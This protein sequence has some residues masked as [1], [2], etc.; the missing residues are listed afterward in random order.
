MWA[1]GTLIV[2]LRNLIK[3]E[4]IP[5]RSLLFFCSMVFKISP[6]NRLFKQVR[7]R[8][9]SRGFWSSGYGRRLMFQRSWVWIPAP[10]TGCKFGKIFTLI[11]CKN[12]IGC[13][14]RPKRGRGLAHFFFKKNQVKLSFIS[15]ESKIGQKT[16]QFQHGEENW[17]EW[18]FMILLLSLKTI[19]WD[20]SDSFLEGSAVKKRFQ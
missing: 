6:C 10:Y 18:E 16:I 17:S 11:C 13:L 5:S 15:R 7:T 12:C 8:E 19:T 14:K 3:W 2:V 20:V 1:R 9:T 4:L